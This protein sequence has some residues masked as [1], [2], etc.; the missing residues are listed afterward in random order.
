MLASFYNSLYRIICEHFESRK[1]CGHLKI[2]QKWRHFCHLSLSGGY[3]WKTL[4]KSNFLLDWMNTNVHHWMNL[5]F[6]GSVTNCLIWSG[7]DWTFPCIFF[8]LGYLNP[9][10]FH[11]YFFHSVRFEKNL[12]AFKMARLIP[13]EWYRSTFFVNE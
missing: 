3:F 12:N 6:I 8:E 4:A 13:F 5:L 9:T 11:H 2:N 10:C 1:K 7:E